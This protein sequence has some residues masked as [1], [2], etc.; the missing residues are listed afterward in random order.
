MINAQA[1]D[2]LGAEV[3]RCMGRKLGNWMGGGVG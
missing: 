3:V 2:E 1:E